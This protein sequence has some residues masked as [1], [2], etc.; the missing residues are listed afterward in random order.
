MKMSLQHCLLILFTYLM[1][2]LPFWGSE[3]ERDF[4]K[5]LRKT[6]LNSSPR[7]AAQRGPGL[8]SVT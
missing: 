4:S 3:G 8:S 7:H 2:Q 6:F 5:I 1:L